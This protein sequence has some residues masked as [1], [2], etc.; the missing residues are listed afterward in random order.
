MLMPNSFLKNQVNCLDGA[1]VVYMTAVLR[2]I[3]GSDEILV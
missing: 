1:V 3:P 2:S